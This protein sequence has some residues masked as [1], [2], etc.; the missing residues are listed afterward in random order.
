MSARKS[1]A[2][3]WT[4]QS[5]LAAL[6]LFAGAMK[7]VMP[8]EAMQQGPIQLPGL[9]IRFIGACEIAGALGLL[10]P[11]LLGIKRVLT[12]IAAVGLAC[13]MTSSTA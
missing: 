13:I 8:I 3:L 6:F 10:L 2:A 5:L 12:P 11:G 9:F 4:V 1:N 7:F